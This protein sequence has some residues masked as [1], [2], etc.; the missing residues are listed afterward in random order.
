MNILHKMI[1]LIKVMM[2]PISVNHHFHIEMVVYTFFFV[3]IE[4]LFSQIK[5]QPFYYHLC[6]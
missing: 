6:Y 4:C 2:L 5:H 1:I 3:G